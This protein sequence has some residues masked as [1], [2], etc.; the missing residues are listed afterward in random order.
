MEGVRR[1]WTLVLYSISQLMSQLQLLHDLKIN[2]SRPSHVSKQQEMQLMQVRTA[3]N[4]LHCT[5]ELVGN[6]H[7]KA[8]H[9]SSFRTSTFWFQ[10]LTWHPVQKFV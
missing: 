8:A 10:F 5:P 4:P 7:I 1:T 3:H 6:E 9:L 2:E